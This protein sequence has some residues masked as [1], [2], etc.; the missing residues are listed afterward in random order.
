M[1][2]AGNDI[3]GRHQEGG[4]AA[5]MPSGAMPDPAPQS[6]R[7]GKAKLAQVVAHPLPQDRALFLHL[8]RALAREAARADDADDSTRDTPRA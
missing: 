2:R 5:P 3:A 4:A 6:R 7:K 8:I 1:A